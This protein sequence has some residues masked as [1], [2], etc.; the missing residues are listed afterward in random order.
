MFAAVLTPPDP[1]TQAMMGI[2]LI[3]LYEVGVVCARVAT[4]RAR[5]EV[6]LGSGGA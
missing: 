2:P 4:R 5:A 3:L 1:F 6:S